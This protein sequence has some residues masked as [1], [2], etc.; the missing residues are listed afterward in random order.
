MQKNPVQLFQMSQDN[1]S[2]LPKSASIWLD[3][4]NCC[5]TVIGKWNKRGGG[6]LFLFYSVYLCFQCVCVLQIWKTQT[7]E[8]LSRVGFVITSA[9]NAGQ[10]RRLASSHK[11]L[12]ATKPQLLTYMC[13]LPVLLLYYRSE[14]QYQP[15]QRP[16]VALS[17]LCVLGGGRWGYWNELSVSVGLCHSGNWGIAGAKLSQEPWTH[18]LTGGEF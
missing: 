6:V 7:C 2:I 8:I 4:T 15:H 9:W 17:A 14:P 16:K 5:L 1:H 3:C 11:Q 12:T 13:Y 18:L 10:S